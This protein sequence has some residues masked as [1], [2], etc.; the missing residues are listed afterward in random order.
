K[1]IRDEKEVL[2]AIEYVHELLDKE[3]AAETSPTD[4][5]VCGMSQ[6]GALAKASVLLYPKTLGGCAIFNGSVPISKSF[7]Q[8]VPS[9]SRKTS[10]MVSWNGSTR[11][12]PLPDQKAL[13]IIFEKIQRKD[14]YGVFVEAVDPVEIY[15][16]EKIIVSPIVS[17]PASS[18]V[19]EK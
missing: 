11:T 15:K 8:K 3:V 16:K 9:E 5:L 14:T 4:I 12:K 7:A 10:I 6:G 19:P 2:K 13:E 18:K 1:T 17:M